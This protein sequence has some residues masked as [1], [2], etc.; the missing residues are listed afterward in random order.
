MSSARCLSSLL[1]LTALLAAGCQRRGDDSPLVA[2]VYGHELHASDLTGLVGEGVSAEDSAAI[3]ASYVDQW[4]RQTV[5]L[6]KAEKNI[7]D[8][9]DRQLR[10]YKNSLLTYAYE[11]QIISQLLDTNISDEQIDEYYE[12]HRED[13]H[14]KS[15]IVKAVYV[16]APVK[17]PAV[18]KL[19]KIID[20]RDFDEHNI[21]ELEETASRH[22]LSGYFDADTWMPFYTLQSAVPITTYNENLYL[23]QNRTITLT[24]NDIIYLV[25]ILDYKVSDETAPLELQTENIRS[26]LLNHRKIDILNRLQNDLLKEAEKGDHVKR[27]I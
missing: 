2:T 25:R 5:L 22:H 15:A 4:I 17:A 3:V 12:Q 11:Q 14:L 26:I 23:K 6:S 13:F 8:N 1:L 10:E 21:V 7:T 16:S 20:K 19:K 9:F 24:D 27:Y 18:A